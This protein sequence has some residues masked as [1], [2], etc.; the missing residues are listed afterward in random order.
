MS[1]RILPFIGSHEPWASGAKTESATCLLGPNPSPMTLDGTNTWIL[2]DEDAAACVLIDPGP[3]DERHRTAI[4]AATLDSPIRMIL[5]TH[6]HGDHSDL[7][8][9]LAVETGAP[10]RALDPRHRLG[11]EGLD[12]GDVVLVGGLEIHVVTSPG[13]TSDSV[14]F[15]LPREGS[16]LTGDT[17]LGRGTSL[18]AWPD[19]RLGD[20][21]LSL[22]H[23]QEVVERNGVRRLLPGHGPILHDPASVLQ[24]YR[25]HRV[26][27]LDE[28]R[29]AALSLLAQQPAEVEGASRVAIE[30]M[31]VVAVVYA[32]VPREVWPAAELS[33]RAQLDYLDQQGELHRG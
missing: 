4:G 13:H 16:L 2:R 25:E 27:R 8:R 19:G 30:P 28:V 11:D 9:D 24:A 10:V 7:A 5:L 17:V 3:N 12:A 29:S 1:G 14:C 6:G 18:V 22:E 26:A 23:L 33:V 20:Y 15:L 21:L 32:A 31:D